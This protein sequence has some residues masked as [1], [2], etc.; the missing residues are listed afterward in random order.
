MMETQSPNPS[1]RLFGRFPL[2]QHEP[3]GVRYTLRITIGMIIVWIVFKAAGVT[4]PI[5]AI[6]SVVMVSE[7]ELQ[8]SY[9]A[10]R[11]RIAHTALGCAV[12][13]IFLA[14]T[15]TGMWQLCAA[16][17]VASLLSFYLVHLGGNWRT[18]PVATVIVM[19]T[20]L[21]HLSKYAGYHAA[22]ERTV[23]VLG[24]SVIALA[25]SWVAAKLWPA[26][27]ENA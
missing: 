16:S 24:G 27:I 21:Q 2:P 25:V 4:Y 9:L 10:A 6:I 26:R 15:G 20:G 14:T 12:G 23:E 22:I 1:R 7:I 11:G 17:A 5:W 18:A 8:A 19:A 13:L 3:N